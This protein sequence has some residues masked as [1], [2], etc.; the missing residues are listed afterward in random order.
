MR[1]ARTEFYA[2]AAM[3]ATV[4]VLAPLAGAVNNDNLC[5][6][7]GAVAM[8]GLFAYAQTRTTPMLLL[9]CGGMIAAS[10][11]KLTGLLLVGATLALAVILIARTAP[12]RPRHL[13]IAAASLALA[14]VPYL[15]FMAQY[16]S[17]APDTP[18]QIN[19][20]ASAARDAGW[21]DQPRLTLLAYA[22]HFLKSFALEWMPTLRPRAPLQYALFV[23]PALVMMAAA[24][25]IALS[26]RA[27]MRRKDA[28]ADG[29]IVAGTAAAILTLAVHIA[30]SY[31]RHLQTG[32]M[33]DAYP[34]YYLPLLAIIPMAAL[35][36]ASIAPGRAR[37]ALLALLIAAPM[38][39]QAFG[40]PAG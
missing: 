16:G 29:L 18:A 34:R 25:G 10:A 9:A 3:V 37:T 7:G 21:S 24:G 39:F 19:M 30:F 12:V 27:V 40:E 1:L 5:I 13:A 2:F 4:P 28:P 33:M 38:I 35:R 32:W 6:A 14:A 11:A 36:L 8:L 20:V 31:Q 23:C 22:G 26:L 17:P 15:V